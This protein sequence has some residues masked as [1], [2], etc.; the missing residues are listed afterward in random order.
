MNEYLV[1]KW[2]HVLSS[3]VLFGT[4]IGTAFQMLMA[5]RSHDPRAVR[6]VNRNVVRADW[7]FTATTVLIQPLTG[8]WLVRISGLP[9][10]TPWI[11]WS[12]VLYAIAV[13]C[14]LPVVWIQMRMRDIAAEAA[15][16]GKPLP[17]I[18]WQLE[19]AWVLLGIPAFLAFVGIFYLMVLKPW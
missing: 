6:V 17:A 2:L 10:S 7:L 12:W 16:A 4:G 1:V 8:W 11:L 14:W 5:N 3:T 18:Y 19:R 13:A 15:H 9:M